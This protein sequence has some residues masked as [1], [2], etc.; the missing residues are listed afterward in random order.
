M[1]PDEILK[2]RLE[3]QRIAH[4]SFRKAEDVVAW[5]GA[6]QAQD[7]LG[8]LWAIGQ[9]MTAATEA[10]VEAAEARRAIVRTWAMRGTLHFV[11]AADARWMTALLAPRVIA[12]N[13]ARWKRD[14]GVDDALVA[15]AD[16]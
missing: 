15:R 3:N 12:R 7:Y 5:F 6:I 10:A 8:S 11:A 1:T 9:R 13:A 4:T 2:L 16:D 14:F